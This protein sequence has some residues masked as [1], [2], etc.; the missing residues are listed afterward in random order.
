MASDSMPVPHNTSFAR[1]GRCLLF[2]ERT[3]SLR[4][5]RACRTIAW[6]KY[7]DHT[8]TREFERVAASRWEDDG[9]APPAGRL[10]SWPGRAS[11]K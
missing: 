4:N 5:C 7:Y 8:G 9:G 6:C 1:E 11:Q 10:Q 3:P 2:A